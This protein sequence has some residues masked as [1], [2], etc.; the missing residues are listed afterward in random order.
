MAGRG[1]GVM[2]GRLAGDSE[3][4]QA[5]LTSPSL[6]EIGE[7]GAGY[8]F[9]SWKYSKEASRSNA[10]NGSILFMARNRH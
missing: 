4:E 2:A 3:S 7:S 8:G 10:A 6:D 9:C 1:A 5:K